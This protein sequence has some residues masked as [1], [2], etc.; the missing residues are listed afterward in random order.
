[1][2]FEFRLIIASIFWLVA[3]VGDLDE[4]SLV[5]WTVRTVRTICTVSLDSRESSGGSERARWFRVA[6]L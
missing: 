6:F 2:V 5:V 4:V 1:M 3:L